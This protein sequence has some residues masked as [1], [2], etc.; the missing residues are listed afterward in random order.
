MSKK[1]KTSNK[2]SFIL[3]LFA[4]IINP[5][6]LKTLSLAPDIAWIDKYFHASCAKIGKWPLFISHHFNGS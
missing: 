6:S 4:D 2:S 3:V 1:I 5:A